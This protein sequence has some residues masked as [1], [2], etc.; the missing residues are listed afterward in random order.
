[1]ASTSDAAAA[2]W[3]R[4]WDS[5]NEPSDFTGS[6]N[7]HTW[8]QDFAIAI[9]VVLPVLALVVCSLRCYIRVSTKNLGWDDYWIFGAMLL[10]IGQAVDSIICMGE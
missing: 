9:E 1:M 8:L 4:L 5:D 10:C 2:L 6:P 7:P 3:L